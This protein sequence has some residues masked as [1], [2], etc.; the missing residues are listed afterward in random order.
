[1]FLHIELCFCEGHWQNRF[2]TG[3]PTVLECKVV[4][5]TLGYENFR[6]IVVCAFGDNSIATA[7][8]ALVCPGSFLLEYLKEQ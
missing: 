5:I 4:D 1:M 3:E 7:L 6:K 8:C 2:G